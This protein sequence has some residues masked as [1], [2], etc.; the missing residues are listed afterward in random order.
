MPIKCAGAPQKA[1]YLSADQW[2]RSGAL[3]QID[4]EF[5]S[6]GAVLFGVADYVPALM[7][8]VKAYGIHLNF[9]N[10]LVR[11]NGPAKIA[12]FRHT[13]ANGK[14]EL[15]DRPFDI[16][17]VVPPQVPPDFIRV[18]PLADAAGWV[19]VIRPRCAT[20]PGQY[21]RA[22]RRRQHAQCQD[23]RRRAQTGARGGA[24]SAGSNRPTQ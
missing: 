23:G 18:S 17:H 2:K 5:C 14:E 24:Q 10:T 21:L 15:I 20:R 3:D 11:V 4:I 1:M 13:G 8:Y 22:G 16:L 6:A 12:T 19:D 7:E 9:G